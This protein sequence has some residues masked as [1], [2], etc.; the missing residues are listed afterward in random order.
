MDGYWSAGAAGHVE[1]GESVLQAAV[2]EAREEL[3][4]II[5]EEDLR[6]LTVMHRTVGNGKPTDERAD[7]FFAAHRWQGEPQ[8][9]EPEKAAALQ[10]ADPMALP[11]PVVP[12]EEFVL[13]HWAR[14]TLETVTTYGF[15]QASQLM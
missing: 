4:V 10:W 12:H 13:H 14:H 8:I 2:R 11:E 15:S 1:A 6:P 5:H 9:Q 3:G 7:F